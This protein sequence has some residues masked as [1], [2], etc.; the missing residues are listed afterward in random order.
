VA[1]ADG[2]ERRSKEG[3]SGI[4]KYDLEKS[5]GGITQEKKGHAYGEKKK[6]GKKK[7]HPYPRAPVR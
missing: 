6:K 1:R 5:F 4:R 3:G 2:G 7:R